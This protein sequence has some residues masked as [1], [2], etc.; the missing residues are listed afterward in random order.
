MTSRNKKTLPILIASLRSEDFLK[1]DMGTVY[2]LIK[3]AI[4][5]IIIVIFSE[6]QILETMASSGLKD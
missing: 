3:I 1:F 6:S 5:P 4:V 2:M